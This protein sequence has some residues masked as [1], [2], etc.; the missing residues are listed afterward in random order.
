M[1]L[2]AFCTML[3]SVMRDLK[4]RFFVGGFLAVLFVVQFV[5]AYVGRGAVTQSTDVR[6]TAAQSQADAM[7]RQAQDIRSTVSP[8]VAG[9]SDSAASSGGKAARDRLD[10]ARSELDRAAKLEREAHALKAASG[11]SATQIGGDFIGLFLITLS[12]CVE[13]GFALCAHFIARIYC[14]ELSIIF[15]NL[16]RAQNRKTEASQP[17]KK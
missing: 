4:T 6:I 11:V 12:L 16:Q 15:N 1:I 13:I 9:L 14:N 7:I 10:S 5:G 17:A 2:A 8:S 3:V